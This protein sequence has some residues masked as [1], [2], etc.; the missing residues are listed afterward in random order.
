MGNWADDDVEDSREYSYEGPAHHILE[1]PMVIRAALH[2]SVSHVLHI[3]AVEGLPPL[4]TAPGETS[5]IPPS[6]FAASTGPSRP[7]PSRPPYKVF[8]GNVPFDATEDDMGTIFYPELSVRKAPLSA[9][10]LSAI[11]SATSK[12]PAGLPL[13]CLALM[14][15]VSCHIIKHRDTQKPRGCFVEF[16]TR[17]DLEKALKKDGTVSLA[18]QPHA[19]A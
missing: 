14:Q 8:I 1:L 17:E 6:T 2:P 9:G 3:N 7:L 16:E 19:H 12:P 15:V 11:M 5:K 13:Q 10:R 4:P 18:Q